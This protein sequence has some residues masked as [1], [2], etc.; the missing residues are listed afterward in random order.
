MKKLVALILSVTMTMC[1][2]IMKS[3]AEDTNNYAEGSLLIKV[4][5]GTAVCSIAPVALHDCSVKFLI[6]LTP[7][8]TGEHS[9]WYEINFSDITTEKMYSL[10]SS[11]KSIL[12]INYN[13]ELNI[14]SPCS[15]PSDDEVYSSSL[16]LEDSYSCGVQQCY[17]AMNNAGIEGKGKG[18]VVAVLDYGIDYTHPALADKIWKNSGEIW[19]D[20]IDNDNNGVID[21]YYGPNFADSTRFDPFDVSSTGH[22]THIAGIIAA[23]GIGIAPDVK[24]MA[25][26]VLGETNTLSNVVNGINYAIKYKAD[27]INMSLGAYG[28]TSSLQ[29]AIEQASASALLFAAAGNEGLPNSTINGIEGKRCYPA[30]F[31]NVIGVMNEM[32]YEGD[33]GWLHSTSN[34]D[35]LTNPVCRY[36]LMAPGMY[37]YSTLPGG[38]YGSLSGTSCSSPYAAGVAALVVAKLKA[39]GN[40]SIN[41]AKKLLLDCARMKLGKVY[42]NTDFYYG[43]INAYNCISDKT[44]ISLN[45]LLVLDNCAETSSGYVSY[46]GIELA[47]SG[48][49]AQIDSISVSCDDANIVFDKDT[50]TLDPIWSLKT[51]DNGIVYADNKAVDVKNPF[52][53]HYIDPTYVAKDIN[54]TLTVVSHVT[55]Q[56]LIDTRVLNT[57]VSTFDERMLPSTLTASYVFVPGGEYFVRGPITV[58]AGNDVTIPDGITLT[59]G[60]GNET[61]AYISVEGNL[62]I[63]GVKLGA[64]ITN[65][66]NIFTCGDGKFSIKDSEIIKPKLTVDSATGCTFRNTS[67]GQYII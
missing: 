67:P 43:E 42:N 58:P 65:Y 49:D 60:K 39:D 26:K 17:D 51:S 34:W 9:V 48:A 64:N 66:V 8:A 61:N 44:D 30:S 54:F 29:S 10:L 5:Y 19:G 46:L 47:N 36:E 31:T 11:C 63:S 15:L 12:D 45:K 20:G 38:N 13:Y 4:A 57:T 3:S 14:S 41:A 23:D 56:S 21:D 16:P 28:Y 37:I 18:L 53:F 22:G 33:Y 35:T 32:D 52:V 55:G 2:S 27:I 59:F 50:I 24:I 6:E 62:N 40:Y 25:I 1:F 7:E